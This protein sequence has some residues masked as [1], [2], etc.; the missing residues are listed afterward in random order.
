MKGL[1]RSA[2]VQTLLAGLVQVYVRL[3]TATLRWRLEGYDLALPILESEQGALILFWHGRI[4]QATACLPFLRGKARAV[5]ISLSRDAGFI[6][7][8]ARALNVSVVRGSTGRPGATLDKGGA[9]AFRAAM[10]VVTRGGMMLLTPDGPR[11]PAEQVQ[12]G[13]AQLARAARAPVLLLG[14]DARP[15]FT[16]GSWD[17]ASLPLPFA[18]AALVVQ[19]VDPP[20]RGED[21]LDQALSGWAAALVEGQARAAR[22]CGR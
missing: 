20:T 17:R 5:M 8:A 6:A 3:I 22:L 19:R 21:E 2:P 1:I 12:A 15:A 4:A 11:G 16:L 18:R 13:A 10:K 7:D 9:T 14:L